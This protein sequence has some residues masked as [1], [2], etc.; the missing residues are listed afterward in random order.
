MVN[1]KQLFC[2]MYCGM[3]ASEMADVQQAQNLE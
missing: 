2:G 3:I 1:L